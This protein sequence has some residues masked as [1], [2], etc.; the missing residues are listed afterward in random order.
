MISTSWGGDSVLRAALLETERAIF[1][2]T[3]TAGVW[4]G[5]KKAEGRWMRPA[6][7]G[8]KGEGRRGL[9]PAQEEGSLGAVYRW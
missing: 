1:N 7:L 6:E 5:G 9:A 4:V 2:K 3:C 8:S